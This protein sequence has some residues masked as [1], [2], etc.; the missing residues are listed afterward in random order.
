MKKVTDYG[1]VFTPMF[2]VSD[3]LDMIENEGSILEPSAGDGMFSK[4]MHSDNMVSIEIDKD[5][6]DI[7]NSLCMDFF[8][9]SIDNKFDTIIGNPPYV[10]FQDILPDTKDKLDMTIFDNRSNLFLFFIEKCIKHL[11][12]NGELIFIVPRE[13]FKATSA[14]KLNEFI[15]NSGTITHMIE[16]GDKKVFEGACPN[17]IIFRFEKDNFSRN[18]EIS[19]EFVYNKGQLLFTTQPY[20]IHF[21]D[22]FDVKVGGVSGADAIYQH[23]DYGNEDFV[24]S[25]TNKTGKTKRMIYNIMHPHL[26]QHKDTLI[27]R[28]IK[29]FNQDNWWKW[30]R[31][32]PTTTVQRIYVNQKTRNDKPFF[33]NDAN[34]FDGAILAV[35]PNK[36]QSPENLK[37]MCD[38]LN[39]VNW[40][41]LGFVVD[42][43]FIFGQKSLKNTLLPSEFKEFIN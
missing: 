36:Q 30:G 34:N 23:D 35:Y 17:T 8:D 37:V 41:E 21:S 6:A 12:P 10:R 39:D 11:N 26:F 33:L 24:C 25:Y 38:M 20:T 1:Q 5:F 40:V 13:L 14:I 3:M 22:I 7:S 4:H 27:N 42:G 16:L 15:Y 19:K 18:T 28:A 9:Y 32:S 2:I 31:N 29:S 43:R